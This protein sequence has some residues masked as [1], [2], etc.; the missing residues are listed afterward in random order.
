VLVDGTGYLS[1]IGFEAA[2]NT[3]I[4]QKRV[5]LLDFLHRLGEAE[6]WSRDHPDKYADVLANE[7]G[8]PADVTRYEVAHALPLPVPVTPT[9]ESEERTTAAH[10]ASAGTVTAPVNLD[11]AFDPS[12]NSAVAH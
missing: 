7:T 9:I 12:F 5:L 6:R 8:L 11:S 1:G 2:N 4:A 3:A 10:F